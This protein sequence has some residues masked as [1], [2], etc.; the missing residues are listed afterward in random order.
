MSLVWIIGVLP[1]LSTLLGGVAAL[2]LHHRLHAV[3]ALAAGILVATALVDLL[4]EAIELIGGEG[5][6][7]TAGAAAVVG[8]LIYAAVEAFIHQGSYEHGHEPTQD[9]R[10][11]H[12]HATQTPMS[13]ARSTLGWLAPSGLI[14]HSMLDGLA[15]GLG[16]EASDEVGIIVLLAVLVHDFADGLNVVT[17]ALAGGRS[18]TAAMV[19]LAI[20]AVAIIVGIGLSQ[21]IAL[22]PDQLG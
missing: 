15:I 10:A 9:P 12:E 19:L 7:L 18:R 2:R 20:D 5:A 4:P 22:A 6:A 17:L 21:V 1:F 14:V 16:F 11:P 13:G 8:Y 3:M